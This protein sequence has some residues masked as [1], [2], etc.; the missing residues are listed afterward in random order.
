MHVLKYYDVEKVCP[1]KV[2]GP[3]FKAQ[4][5]QAFSTF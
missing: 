1:K 3:M 5:G 4:L 2:G